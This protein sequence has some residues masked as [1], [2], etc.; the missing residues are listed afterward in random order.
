MSP[1]I[2]FRFVDRAGR[3]ITG[4][5]EVQGYT[6]RD[7]FDCDIATATDAELSAAYKGADSDGVGVRWDTA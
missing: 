2:T 5:D 6:F 4:A 3:D 1:T 7:F